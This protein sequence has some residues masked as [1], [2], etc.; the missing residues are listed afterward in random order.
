MSRESRHRTQ[1]K[2]SI[3]IAKELQKKRLICQHQQGKKKK[4]HGKERS[5]KGL[6]RKILRRLLST[7]KRVLTRLSFSMSKQ[8]FEDA[9]IQ[10]IIGCQMVG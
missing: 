1:R 2:N 10:V 5:K 6:C 8:I 4:Q 3:E 9:G 7:I